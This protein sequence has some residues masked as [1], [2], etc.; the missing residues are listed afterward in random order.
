[1]QLRAGKKWLGTPGVHLWLTTTAHM[2]PKFHSHNCKDRGSSCSLQ[3][4]W[5]TSADAGGAIIAII[6]MIT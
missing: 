4:S 5:H 2:N 6:E 3:H 1:M